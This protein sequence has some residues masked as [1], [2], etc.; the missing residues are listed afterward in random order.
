MIT[1]VN[2]SHPFNS[3]IK[4]VCLASMNAFDTCLIELKQLRKD[5]ATKG[6]GKLKPDL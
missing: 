2:N 4:L 6:W 5:E 1:T 3:H